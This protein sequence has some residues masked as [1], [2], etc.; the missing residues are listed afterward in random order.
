MKPRQLNGY[1]YAIHFLMKRDSVAARITNVGVA[2]RGGKI[3]TLMKSW[4]WSE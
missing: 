4:C 3:P 1:E 2:F